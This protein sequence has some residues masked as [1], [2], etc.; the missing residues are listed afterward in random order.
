[1]IKL[2]P[3]F[4]PRALPDDGM[5]W[6]YGENGWVRQTVM[7]ARVQAAYESGLLTR[8]EVASG[9]GRAFCELMDRPAKGELRVRFTKSTLRFQIQTGKG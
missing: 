4:D 9:Y 5:L 3:D 8:A 1:M 7:G 2:D 6:H